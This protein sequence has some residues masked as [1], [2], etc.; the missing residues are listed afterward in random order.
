MATSI[1]IKYL[2]ENTEEI[3][4]S[5]LNRVFKNEMT[6]PINVNK[7]A[8]NFDIPVYFQK[9]D[10]DLAGCFISETGK[11][12]IAINSKDSIVRQRFTL[13][14]ELGHFISYKFQEKIGSIFD[15]RGVLASLGVDPEEIFANKFAAEI[16]MPKKEFL[17]Q[18]KKSNGD[19]NK[20]SEY[21][22]VSKYAI[23]IRVKTT[24]GY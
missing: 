12:A 10:D 11:S 9:L 17:E 21:F 7:I 23:E 3:A 24:I 8:E 13:A 4:Q 14:H 20:V 6:Y 1:D 5:V 16:L 19:V 22:N 18:M 2:L 15:G